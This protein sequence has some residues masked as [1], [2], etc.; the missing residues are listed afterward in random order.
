MSD[1]KIPEP[2]LSPVVEDIEPNEE[3]VAHTETASPRRD[4]S[5]GLSELA[6]YV[7]SFLILASGAGV[8]YSL[9]LL[10]EKPADQDS[11]ELVTMVGTYEASLYSGELAMEVSG[12]VVPFREI[13][14]AAEISGNVIKK[15][16]DFEAGNFVKKGTRLLEI[17]PADYALQLKTREAEVEQSKKALDEVKEEIVGA[18]RNIKL[19]E[20]DFRLAQSEYQRNLRIKSAL[21]SSE[22]DQSKR[23][24]LTA[25]SA[26]T[27]RRNSLDM[28]NAKQKRLEAALALSNANLNRAQLSLDRTTLVA[29]DD[30][31]IVREMVQEGDYVR[32]GDQIVT[33]EDTSRSEVICNLT[34][35]D[36]NW[37]RENSPASAEFNTEEELESQSVYYLP[38]TRVTVYE[39]GNPEIQWDGILERFD[40]IG[41]DAAT[42]TIPCRV[43]IEKPIVKTEIGSRALVRGMYVKCKI[44]VQTSPSS[45]KRKFVSL[46]S[47]ALRPGDFVWV[48][49]DKKLKKLSVDVVHYTQ[50]LIDDDQIEMV[51]VQVKNG[52]VE[53]GD[54]VVTTPLTQ[55]TDGQEVILEEEFLAKNKKDESSAESENESDAD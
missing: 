41:R 16:P 24:L 55:P 33:F 1:T 50:Q 36:L 21:S 31:V 44:Q 20:D 8:A 42:R 54:L 27:Q 53:K 43:S 38:K 26:L 47:I 40:G 13:R 3:V 10:K 37:V 32:A 19:A 2:E 49:K 30:G 52:S 29:P 35:T 34:S 45:G 23:G 51:V 12:S 6:K 9:S 25:E 18:N 5:S 39:P 14:V 15:F 22:L 7:I 11:K 48:V 46:P 17:D 4:E 28:M